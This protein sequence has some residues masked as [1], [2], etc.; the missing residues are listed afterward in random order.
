MEE[1]APST[2]EEFE[3]VAEEKKAKEAQKGVASQ[4]LGKAIDGAEEAAIGKPKV[5]SVKNRYKG[6]E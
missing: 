2:A 6:G 3:R 1:R 5:E 4:T